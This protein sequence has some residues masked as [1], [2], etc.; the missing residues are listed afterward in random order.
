MPVQAATEIARLKLNAD[1]LNELAAEDHKKHMEDHE[2]YMEAMHIE[3]QERMQAIHIEHEKRMQPL[4][5][6]MQAILK[7]RPKKTLYVGKVK[8]E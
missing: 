8:V 1:I 7:N 6:H 2:K 5:I 4:K 3:H